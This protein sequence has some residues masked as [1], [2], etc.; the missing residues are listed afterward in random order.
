[1]GVTKVRESGKLSALKVK[2]LKGLGRFNDGRGLYLVVRPDSKAWVFRY[3]DRVSRKLRDVGLGAVADVSLEA[4]RARRDELRAMLANGRDPMAERKA[5]K[6][7]NA[8]AVA[9]LMTFA[10]CRDAYIDAHAP[11]WRNAKHGAQWR[12]T[13]TNDAALLSKISVADVT[14]DLVMTVLEP[15]W[16]VKTETATRLR[17]RIEAV[18]DWATVRKYRSGDNPARWRGHLDKLLASP[19]K[20]RTVKHQAAMPHAEL[21]KFMIELR[22]RPGLSARLLELVILTAARVSEAAAAHWSEFDLDSGVWTIPPERMKA[23]REHRV[24]LSARAVQLLRDLPCKEGA[25]HVFPGATGKS[26]L[27]PESAR[28]LLQKDMSYSD[29]TVHGF[30][31]SFRDWA[32]EMTSFPGDVIEAAL[33]HTIKDKT[34]A[35]YKRTD[36]FVKRASLMQDWCDYISPNESNRIDPAL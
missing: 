33:A 6:L 1:M 36:L 8:L 31:S 24:A 13:L 9:K 7:A 14:T 15:I 26:H 22:K 17:Q 29:I 25:Q 35:A 21:P 28:K 30:R 23:G 11:S 2:A 4:A 27:N 32:A 20:V 12:A 5:A 10:Q 19:T 16:T 3:R 18:L 34:E